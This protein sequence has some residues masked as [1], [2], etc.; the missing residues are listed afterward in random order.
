MGMGLLQHAS[1]AQ[2]GP[3][4]LPASP[5]KGEET[6]AVPLKLKAT[7]VLPLKGRVGMGL[8]EDT[9]AAQPDP[10]PLP[11]SPLKAEEAMTLPFKGRV[12]MGFNGD[13]FG[14]GSIFRASLPLNGEKLV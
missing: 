11:S 12:G 4:P 6:M 7:M 3:I 10:I 8:L 5:L 2:P 9:P 13:T 14:A 1:G